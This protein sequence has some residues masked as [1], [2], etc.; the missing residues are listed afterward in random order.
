MTHISG[1]SVQRKSPPS[2][3][4]SLHVTAK[5]LYDDPS[6]LCG[7]HAPAGRSKE[8]VPEPA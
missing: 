2:S 6:Q 7:S 5:M 8:H 1:R 4:S 3:S